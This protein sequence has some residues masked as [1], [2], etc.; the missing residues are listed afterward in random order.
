MSS[1]ELLRGLIIKT[2]REAIMDSTKPSTPPVD[3]SKKVTPATTGTADASKK[4]PTSAAVKKTNGFK[5]SDILD[6]FCYPTMMIV[7]LV[8]SMIIVLFSTMSIF[9]KIALICMLLLVLLVYYTQH[10]K[11][12]FTTAKGTAEER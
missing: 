8:V 11:P 7:P 9:S 2:K 5:C 1:S 10:I 3:P 4:A 6:K 12:Y